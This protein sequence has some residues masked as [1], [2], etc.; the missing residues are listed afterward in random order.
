MNITK[1]L[2]EKEDLTAVHDSDKSI[3]EHLIERVN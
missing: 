2:N 1:L 3:K